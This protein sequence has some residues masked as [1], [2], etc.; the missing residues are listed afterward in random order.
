[1][2]LDLS[3]SPA[4]SNYSIHEPLGQGSMSTIHRAIDLRTNS[5]CAIKCISIPENPSSRWLSQT[6]S[7]LTIVR[8]LNHPRIVR[9]HEILS[10]DRAHFVVFELLHD[11]TLLHHL[12]VRDHFSEA[13]VRVIFADILEGVCYLHGSV[14]VIHRDL[15]LE[16]VMFDSDRRAKIIDFGLALVLPAEEESVAGEICGSL[17]Y[18]SPEM[19]SG[20][21]CSKA[22]DIWSLGVM[23]FALVTGFFPFEDDTP[24]MTIT[25]IMY[26][27]TSYPPEITGELE[28][29]MDRMLEKDPEKRIRVEEI[30]NHKWMEMD[31]GVRTVL[32]SLRRIVTRPSLER[33]V[34][35][36]R[37]KTPTPPLHLAAGMARLRTLRKGATVE[38]EVLSPTA[39]PRKFHPSFVNERKIVEG[40]V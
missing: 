2:S 10:D 17:P 22:T 23:L 1:M 29:L 5:E 7:E 38:G 6:S 9:C 12:H 34:L 27:D 13:D 25:N 24:Q 19:L 31:L 35:P 11:G 4:L 15:K 39:R 36:V 3:K 33:F 21:K 28:D 20:R 32:P 14:R 18:A 26:R 8:L 37:R 30:G 16:N 40:R